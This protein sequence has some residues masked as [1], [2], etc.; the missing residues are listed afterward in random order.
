MPN[1]PNSE[2]ILLS[3]CERAE[4][5]LCACIDRL[6]EDAFYDGLRRDIYAAI[7]GL[8]K[9]GATVDQ[10]TIYEAMVRDK[11]E[12]NMH[13]FLAC[14]H[15]RDTGA[16][17]DAGY[18]IDIL[19]NLA[20]RRQII[21]ASHAALLMA[22]DLSIEVSD[23]IDRIGDKIDD[24]K[25]DGVGGRKMAGKLMKEYEAM[26]PDHPSVLVGHDRYI[27]KG[28]TGVI[29]APSSVGKSSWSVQ[30]IVFWAC[31]KTFM[32]LWPRKALKIVLVLGEDD[33]G[34]VGEVW[35]A[36]M[37]LLSEEERKVAGE[38]IMVFHEHGLAGAPFFD[39]V[40]KAAKDF[41]ADIVLINPLLRY[42]GV[43]IAKPA[44]VSTKLWPWVAR[45]N[46][47][48]Q[49]ATIFIHHTN[50]IAPASA[51][52]TKRKWNEYMYGMG[53]SAELTNQPRFIIEV[54]PTEE[55]GKF[56]IRL[57][58][59]G[60]RAGIKIKT[61]SPTGI[62]V[63]KTVD[64]F[65]AWWTGGYFTSKRGHRLG[66]F[67]WEWDLTKEPAPPQEADEKTEKRKK[68]MPRVEWREVREILTKLAEGEANAKPVQTLHR[69]T[70]SLKDMR[71]NDF[72]QVLSDWCD[73]GLMG[74]SAGGY[75]VV[76]RPGPGKIIPFRPA[77]PAPKKPVIED[78]DVFF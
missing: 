73:E 4:S 72:A 1:S 46:P 25:K 36:V 60:H 49:W 9:Q 75:Y 20:K 5:S 58:K 43:D 78:D 47:D 19:L 76:P 22:G 59:R 45:S 65:L 8:A 15:P 38:N 33:E 53:G 31:G 7:L 35:E 23:V 14:F 34:D 24:V 54:E 6:S 3:E 13:E 74:R 56:G 55:R 44:E 11:R 37:Q 62:E 29:F 63:W 41:D 10:A 18:H 77:Q 67:T 69:A 16:R 64:Y 68:A 12:V 70:Q 28:A 42:A 32:G 26:D 48:K 66:K 50:K 57:A 2:M 71:V 40:G 51:G 27:Y 61:T 39:A 52:N 30:L 17:F 21:R